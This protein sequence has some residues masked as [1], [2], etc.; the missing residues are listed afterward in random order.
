M[1]N[2]LLSIG[3]VAQR[4]GLAA[5]AVRFYEK[6]GL[7]HAE[8]TPGNQRLFRR[9]V[10][11]RLAFIRIAQKV[12]LSLE[13]IVAALEELS[14]DKAPSAKDWQ[15]LTR[16]WRE[17]IDQRIELLEALRSGLSTCIGC[18]CLSLRTCALANPGDV[19]GRFGSGPQYLMS[20]GDG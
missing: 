17:R 18:G 2:N 10:L 15:H 14:V 11:R 5:S 8:R 3:E 20:D 7:V 13:E 16:G 12:G 1:S 4:S 6:A 19:A 9:D